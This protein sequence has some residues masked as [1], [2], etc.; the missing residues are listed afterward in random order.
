MNQELEILKTVAQRLEEAGIAYMITGSIAANFYAVPRMTRDIDLVIEIKRTDA[1]RLMTLFD[2]DFYIDKETIL[3]AVDQYGMFNIIHN[4]YVVKVDFIVRKETPYRQEEFKRRR[5]INVEG[6][7]LWITSPEDLI[8]SKLVWAKDS[9]S[10]IQLGD[11]KNI[12][13]MTQNIDYPYLERWVQSLNL[14]DM[15]NRAKK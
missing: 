4:E 2:R 14:E 11:V 12:L 7:P 8:L 1:D 3:E 10:E 15:Y 9:L 5:E 13:N 6:I